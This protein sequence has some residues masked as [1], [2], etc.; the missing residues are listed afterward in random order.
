MN[1]DAD[2]PRR[3]SDARFAGRRAELCG[4]LRGLLG[5]RRAPEP[6]ADADQAASLAAE[7]GAS[8]RA[9]RQH[10]WAVVRQTWPAEDRGGVAAVLQAMSVHLG[11]RTA[12]L[13]LPG[14]EPQAV[15]IDSEAVLDNPLGFAALADGELVVLDQSVPA[16]LWLLGPASGSSTGAHLWELDVWGAEPWLSAATRALREQGASGPSTD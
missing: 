9:V 4:A 2:E 16:G 8:H 3:A 15:P 10:A 12:W 13:I 1:D 6:L 11:P 14:R 7:A 5:A